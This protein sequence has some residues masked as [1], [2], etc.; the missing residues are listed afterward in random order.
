MRVTCTSVTNE[1]LGSA[2]SPDKFAALDWL[3]WFVNPAAV[4]RRMVKRRGGRIVRTVRVVSGRRSSCGAAKPSFFSS[5]SSPVVGNCCNP[6]HLTKAQKKI[7][8]LQ[9]FNFSAARRT[10]RLA[11]RLDK[12]HIIIGPRYALSTNLLGTSLA[13]KGSKIFL[14]KAPIALFPENIAILL[15]MSEK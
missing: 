10:V 14:S 5:G 2:E 9:L 12:L 3:G 7:V 15:S 11:L 1:C 6:S 4:R 13:A 8:I